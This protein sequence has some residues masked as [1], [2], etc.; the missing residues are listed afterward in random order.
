MMTRNLNAVTLYALNKEQFLWKTFFLN[1]IQEWNKRR[2]KYKNELVY[3]LLNFVVDCGSFCC[4]WCLH[5]AYSNKWFNESCVYLFLFFFVT[6]CFSNV[7][8]D[9]WLFGWPDGWWCSN[10]DPRFSCLLRQWLGGG[11]LDLW[12]LDVDALAGVVQ[13]RSLQNDSGRANLYN[14]RQS[15]KIMYLHQPLCVSALKN[16][17]YLFIFGRNNFLLRT[18]ILCQ[19][20]RRLEQIIVF[21]TLILVCYNGVKTIQ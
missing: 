19:H 5:F 21:K 1:P 13:G 4:W 8:E 17:Y 10:K 16:H 7:N 11:S 9:G 15:L 20:T 18:T 6:N 3:L 2:R 14:K 12:K